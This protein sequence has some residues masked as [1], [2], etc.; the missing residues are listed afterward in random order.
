MAGKLSLLEACRFS[1]TITIIV[2]CNYILHLS[3]VHFSWSYECLIKQTSQIAL[4][5]GQH[6]DH[7]SFPE[8]F[9]ELQGHNHGENLPCGVVQEPSVPLKSKQIDPCS[10]HLLCGAWNDAAVI[11]VHTHCAQR[12]FFPLLRGT[13]ASLAAQSCKTNASKWGCSC[14]LVSIGRSWLKVCHR[15]NFS[16]SRTFLFMVLFPLW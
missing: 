12:W 8:V 3:T 9:G 11:P 7:I 6:S 13:E 2:L 14:S 4:G 10:S 5:A 16:F 15:G 1:H